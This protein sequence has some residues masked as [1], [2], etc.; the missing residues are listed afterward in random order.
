MPP[1]E[2]EDHKIFKV[3]AVI[4]IIK[5]K[6]Q[7]QR[8]YT[9]HENISIDESMVSYRGKTPHLRQ[10]MPNKHHARFGIKV[11][12]ICD[13]SSHYTVNF[14]IYKGAHN[15]QDRTEE[16]VTHCLVMRL[17]RETDLLHQGY[18]VG[19]DNYFS[20]PKLFFELLENGT[21]ATGTVRSHRKGLPK[22]LLATRLR[23]QEV[24]ERRK[25][26][27]LCVAYKDGSKRPVLISTSSKA[28][29]SETTNARG[30]PVTRPN[31]VNTYNKAMG[32]VDTSDAR[33]YAYLTE[34]RSMKWSTKLVFSL[35]GRCMF[36]AAILYNE[37]TTHA[38]K[39]S[40]YHFNVE[41]L[42]ALVGEYKPAKVNRKRRSRV[43][44]DAARAAADADQ[45]AQDAPLDPPAHP[46]APAAPR[47]KLI[48]IGGGL[49]RQCMHKHQGRQR[50]VWKCAECDVTLCPECF[51]PYHSERGLHL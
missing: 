22:Q 50:T 12:C 26:R 15:A 9:P 30:R 17:L 40:R 5:R 10:Y 49:R 47:H 45:P 37:H 20:S 25:G 44:I 6:F 36:N 46:Y 21:L 42:E 41:V 14:E 27:L 31:V 32:G 4:D 13:A 3:Q 18:H 35:L 43:E 29:M 8:L 39:L 11:W 16:G 28:G 48:K 34:R 23:N 38:P 7:T 1:P 51:A 24:C 2:H 33:L 19:L